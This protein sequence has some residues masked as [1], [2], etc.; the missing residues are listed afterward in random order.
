MR[1]DVTPEEWHTE[2][3]LADSISEPNSPV[4]TFASFVVEDGKLGAERA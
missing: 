4:R 1:C 3:K 2:M